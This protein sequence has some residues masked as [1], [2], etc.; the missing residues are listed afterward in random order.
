MSLKYNLRWTLIASSIMVACQSTPGAQSE[1]AEQSTAVAVAANTT[2]M[3][4]IW[5]QHGNTQNLTCTANDVTIANASNIRDLAGKPLAQCVQGQVFSFIADFKVRLGAQTRFDIGLYFA[6]DGDGN[7]DGALTGT[8]SGSIIAP[9]D[10]LNG[11]GSVNFIQLDPA[12]DTCGDI[13]SAHNPQVVTVR[14]DNVLCQDTDADGKLNLPNCTSWRQPGSNAVCQSVNDAFPGSPSKCHC[15]IAFNVPIFVEPGS[16]SVTK[17]P[18]PT[19]LPAP[20]GEFTFTV[21]ATNTASFTNVTIEKICDDR[22]G[23]IA[24]IPGTSCPAGTL[25][26][27][28]STDCNLPLPQ[29]LA[30]GAS[31]SC[32]F[33]ANLL[34]NVATT[35]TDTVTVS[36]H[37]TN[38]TA[39]SALAIA[40]VAVTNAPPT[41]L[42]IKSLDS[43]QCSIVRYKV[44]V[45]N[46]SLA[47]TLELKALTDSSFGDLLTAHDNVVATTCAICATTSIASTARCTGTFDAKF[48]GGKDIDT[49][50]AT[51]ND[52]QGNEVQPKSNTLTVNTSATTTVP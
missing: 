38:G 27:K 45:K 29:P 34:S 43:M 2:C 14:V 39:V 49:I 1:L 42:V 32:T 19:S 51:L 37:D 15:D 50:T 5:F 17:A 36:G 10:P 26:T 22:Y 28:N 6:T 20:G 23:T 47:G 48:C 33:K 8:C 7:H 21:T 11:L 4:D 31:Y 52:G 44:E 13:D 46:T 35:D 3:Q 9:K 30:P 16:I 25:G 18:S 40:Q 12:P 24:T 41:A